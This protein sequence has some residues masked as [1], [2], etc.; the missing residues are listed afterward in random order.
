[1]AEVH[2]EASDGAVVEPMKVAESGHETFSA[3]VLLA[4][5]GL[6]L[7]DGG[8]G[9]SGLAEGANEGLVGLGDVFD[10]PKVVC[11]K[12]AKVGWEDG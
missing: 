7:G 10:L 3:G 12:G 1:M 6:G 11:P 5:G 2:R 4:S 9:G 8:L